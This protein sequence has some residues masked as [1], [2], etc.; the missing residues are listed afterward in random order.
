MVGEREQEAPF[1]ER[2]IATIRRE[3]LDGTVFWTAADLETKHLDFQRYYNG[4]AHTRGWTGAR[5]SRARTRAASARVSVRIDGSRTV[6]GC[7]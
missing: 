3:C 1:V 4:I 6:V 7:I 5:R 2:L